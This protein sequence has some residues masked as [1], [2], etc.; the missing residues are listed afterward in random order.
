[1]VMYAFNKT[2]FS[3]HLIIGLQGVMTDPHVAADGYTYE[4]TELQGWL[5]NHDTSPM[6]NLR[7]QNHD[8]IPN[9]PLRSAIQQWQQNH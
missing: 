2:Y 4:A 7:L 9:H 6:T 8:L 5:E 1:M 3:I